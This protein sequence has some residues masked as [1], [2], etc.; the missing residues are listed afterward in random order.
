MSQTIEVSSPP[1]W[2]DTLQKA[3]SLPENKSQVLYQLATVDAKNVPHVRTVAH[4]GILYPAGAPHLPVFLLST[5]IRTDKV[6]QARENDR[7][8]FAWFLAGTQEQYRVAGRVR[9]I[10]GPTHPFYKDAVADLT[11]ALRTM[12]AQ[13]YDWE[14]KRVEGYAAMDGGMR[15]HYCS[16]LAGEET[17]EEK[18][19]KWPTS[20]PKVAG[21]EDEEDKRNWERGLTNV[22]LVL[23][24]PEEVVHVVHSSWP[25]KKTK[26]IRSESGEWEE[27]I[28]EP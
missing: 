5:D 11:P 23:I 26:F 4:R 16:P 22:S 1:K 18:G 14:K 20:V 19:I 3:L 17:D 24:E 13:G 28:I 12:N 21:V 8:E 15:A 10:P 9:V 27:K 7:V 2:I 6:A 25:N